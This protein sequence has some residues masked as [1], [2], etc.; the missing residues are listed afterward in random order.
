M[1]RAAI[2]SP[3]AVG[4]PQ[5]GSRSNTY[6]TVSPGTVGVRAFRPR[7]NRALLNA[8][9]RIGGDLRFHDF[10]CR[11]AFGWRDARGM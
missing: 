10:T 8:K 2:Q 6:R 7:K 4:L 3:T 9:S 5:A 1:L 11:F